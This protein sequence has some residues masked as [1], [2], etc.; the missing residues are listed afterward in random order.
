MEVTANDRYFKHVPFR[1]YTC[2]DSPFSQKLVKPV[3]DDGKCKTLKY[4]MEEVYPTNYNQC[5]FY[6]LLIIIGNDH[7]N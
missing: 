5:K 4:L 1:C 3:T 7:Q 6:T 2:E